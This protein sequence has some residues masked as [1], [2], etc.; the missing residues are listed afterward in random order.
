MSSFAQQLVLLKTNLASLGPRRLSALGV[1]AVTVTA[2]VSAVG[3]YASRPETEPLYAGLAQADVSRIGLALQESGIPY[4]VSFDG[5]KVMVRRAQAA[6]A[7]MLLAE[8]GLPSGGTSGYEV[9][10]KLGALGLTS[11]M[12]DV[13]R[14]RAIEGELSRSIGTMKGVVSARV[15]VVVPSVSSFKQRPGETSAS[16]LLRPEKSGLAAGA[17]QTIRHLVAAA[18]PGMA[19]EQVS[20][21]S[22]DG[23]VLA[24]AG[25][26]EALM[27][28]RKLETEQI[29]ARRAQDS[30]RRTLAPY[31]GVE[32]FEVSAVVR[33]DMDRRRFQEQT[34]DP[35]SKVER[36]TRT[37]REQGA[38]QSANSKQGVTVE[39][40]VP[41]EANG[42]TAGDQS[43][44]SNERRDKTVNFEVN[45]KTQTIVS[46]THKIENLQVSIVVNRKRLK[47]ASDPNA[48]QKQLKEI[49]TIAGAA[50]GVN[51][52][53]GDAIAVAAVE[54]QDLPGAHASAPSVMERLWMHLDTV[55]I[56]VTAIAALTIL[57]WFGL[58]PAVSTIMKRSEGQNVAQL[59][60]PGTLNAEIAT[61]AGVPLAIENLA[62]AADQKKPPS[63]QEKLTELVEKDEKLVADILR[64]W[65]AK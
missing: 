1:A 6:K 23:N 61:A 24:A 20:V 47:D 54:F 48:L 45:S 41:T 53:R 63:L 3:Y 14:T 13:S 32:N 35:E 44:K 2:L 33:V 18:V 26:S 7:R 8:R 65:V 60:P 10:D 17:A 43:K 29:I 51:A 34:W 52:S 38:S 64:Q 21:M 56:S 55:I 59:A 4:D 25:G 58:L 5:T 36:S 28:E 49:E 9:F 39:Q 62:A 19:P 16:V 40:N 11:F 37:V 12:Q 50:A 22:T 46:E 15:H 27:S 42:P 31:L 57:V 30:V